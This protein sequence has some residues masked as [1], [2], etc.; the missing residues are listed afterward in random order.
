MNMKNTLTKLETSKF[1]IDVDVDEASWKAAQ[2][3][4][5]RKLASKVSIPGF[6]PGKAPEAML[7]A[8]VDPSKA[9]DVALNDI[10]N[11]VFVQAVKETKIRPMHQPDVE[12]LKISDKDL[13]LRFVVITAPEVTLGAYTGLKAERKVAEVTDD[14]VS[15][16]I[17]KLLEGNA[18]LVVTENPAKMGDTVVLDFE[19]FIDG[20]AFEGGKAE[21]YTLEL[22]SNSFIPGF[23]EALVGAKAGETR[24]VKVTFPTQYV[25]ELAGKDAT[26]VCVIHDVKEKVVPVLSD[27]AV[28]DLEIKDVATVEQLKAHQK[29]TLLKE[30]A[31]AAEREHYQALFEQILAGSKVEIAKE[32]VDEDVAR[33]EENTK[34]QVESN[35]LTFK[36]YLEVLGKT[37]EQLKDELR[38]QVTKNLTAYLVSLEICAKE[39]LLVDDAELDHEFAKIADQYSMTVEQ[40]K[41]AYGSNVESFRDTLR[42]KKLQDFLL[43]NNE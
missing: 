20:V 43:A 29:E 19:G 22:G 1:Q 8:R 2:E 39:H 42:Q 14:E 13:T 11:D 38:A 32:L 27:E 25:A 31:D 18:D 26:F 35:G 21:N 17:A 12:L 36:Q 15:A 34:K 6:R 37:E 10:L 16:S 5:I 7:R 4:A 3:K 41:S 33:E 28:A 30:K 23:E 24:D 40:V 9:I